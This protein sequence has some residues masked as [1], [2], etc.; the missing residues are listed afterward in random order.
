M[1]FLVVN[2]LSENMEWTPQ[3]T[4]GEVD[5]MGSSGCRST[6]MCPTIMHKK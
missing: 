4:S 1:A 6:S 2:E 3:V 5:K